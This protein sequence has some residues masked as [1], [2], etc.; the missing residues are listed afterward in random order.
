M[1]QQSGGLDA[2]GAVAWIS[3]A[4]WLKTLASSVLLCVEN[5]EEPL[6]SSAAQVRVSMIVT[7]ARVGMT[8]TIFINY[9]ESCMCIAPPC[10]PC[11]I[12]R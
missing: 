5:A 9:V 8:H 10:M 11:S 3:I 1:S 12:V 4:L 6:R 7:S 2:A